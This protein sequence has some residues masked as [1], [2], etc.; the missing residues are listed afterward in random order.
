MD[1]DE[2]RKFYFTPGWQDQGPRTS[3]AV[4]FSEVQVDGFVSV[5]L[6]VTIDTELHSRVIQHT[7]RIPSSSKV[8]QNVF[9]FCEESSILNFS[10]SL[11]YFCQ[12]SFVVLGLRAGSFRALRCA[13]HNS[14]RAQY[15]G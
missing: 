11:S 7:T 8:F 4:I 10:L 13:N 5:L 12:D 14:M 2:V 15:F 9:P 1:G 3:V 6:I